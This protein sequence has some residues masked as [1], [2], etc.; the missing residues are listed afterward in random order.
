M[1]FG[2]LRALTNF[3]PVEVKIDMRMTG[4][5]GG[6]AGAASERSPF[7]GAESIFSRRCGGF[8]GR[9]SAGAAAGGAAGP[10]SA[11]AETLVSPRAAAASPGASKIPGADSTISRGCGEISER[12]N[13]QPVA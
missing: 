4:N 12:G 8:S 13:S 3:K 10:G 11:G 1:P 2:V 6:A 7:P 9:T 5:S